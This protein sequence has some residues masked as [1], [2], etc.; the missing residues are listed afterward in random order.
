MKKLTF[1]PLICILLAAAVSGTVLSCSTT[2]F[3]YPG[4]TENIDKEVS[5]TIYAPGVKTADQ[6]FQFFKEN[7]P[8]GKNL[9]KAKK[10]AKI[11]ISECRAEGI[12]S[13]VAFIQMCHETGYLTYGNLVQ[14]EWNNFCGLGAI[15]AE[16]P[17]LKFKTMELGVRAH[18][19]HL[20]AYGS[21]ED[22]VLKNEIVDPRYKYVRP[23]G[24]APDVFGLAGTWAADK[25]YGIKL[26]NLLTK[27][28][29]IGRNNSIIL[30]DDGIIQLEKKEEETKVESESEK[31]PEKIIETIE[32]IKEIIETPEVIWEKVELD[33]ELEY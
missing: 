19:Q 30:I 15:N 16:Q 32:E 13:D 24:K 4:K 1:N 23:R 20:H 3:D 33:L 27:L 31:I 10:L 22:V 28:D 29:R 14:P 26:D 25:Q 2:S 8:N 11:Y 21:T 9:S 18:V 17:G 6:L 5:R 12:N 7:C